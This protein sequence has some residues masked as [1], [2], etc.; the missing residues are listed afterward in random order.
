MQNGKQSSWLIFGLFGGGTLSLVT[1][2]KFLVMIP[3]IFTRKQNVPWSDLFITGAGVFLVGFICGCV[4]WS[5][6]KLSGSYI[7]NAIIGAI[8]INIYITL[9]MFIFVDR[10]F[11]ST[12]WGGDKIFG[13]TIIGIFTVLGA[14]M[15]IWHRL[16]ERRELQEEQEQNEHEPPT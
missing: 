12:L 3:G 10:N 6:R 5:L 13:L 16:D 7:G 15:G 2:L 1:V 4:I 8:T 11:F 9:I 14:G